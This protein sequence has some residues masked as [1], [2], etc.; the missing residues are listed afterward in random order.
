MI[1]KP[2]SNKENII[3][4]LNNN[5]NNNFD[6]KDKNIDEI[7]N[8][9]FNNEI[10]SFLSVVNTSKI[11]AP[12][13]TIKSNYKVKAKKIKLSKKSP[14]I[15]FESDESSAEEKEIEN[16]DNFENNNLEEINNLSIPSESKKENINNMITKNQKPIQPKSQKIENKYMDKNNRISENDVIDSISERN[17]EQQLMD[18]Y[19]ADPDENNYSQVEKEF[20]RNKVSKISTFKGNLKL[21]NYFDEIKQKRFEL[22]CFELFRFF[23]CNQADIIIRKKN[24][25]NGG[26]ALIE[27][28][29]DVVYL[30]KKM[31]EFDRFKSLLLN[32]DQLLLLDSLSKFMLDRECV[33]INNFTSCH[34]EKFIDIY[35][36]I[37]KGDSPIDMT[38]SRWVDKKYLTLNK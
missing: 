34:Y 37:S 31:L 15:N 8:T 29:T 9:N 32:N 3:S 18:S 11:K 35:T 10:N 30:I 23:C 20:Y 21:K 17:N 13:N 36:N 27:E 19:F 4:K 1:K 12:K 33:D 22:S 26:K 25:F 7:K 24:I 2:S 16:L 14:N 38:L 6:L 5:L 28:R